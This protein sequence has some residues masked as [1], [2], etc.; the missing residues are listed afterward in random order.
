MPLNTNLQDELYDRL[1][2]YC[3]NHG[4]PLQP[5]KAY[6]AGEYIYRVNSIPMGFYRLTQ[7]GI[8]LE[9]EGEPFS[10]PVIRII[11]PHEFF[12]GIGPILQTTCLE[13]AIVFDEAEVQLFP[14]NIFTSL[15]REDIGFANFVIKLCCERINLSE[16]RIASLVTLSGKQRLALF[17]L[18]LEYVH[19][20]P[21]VKASL[22]IYLLK[23]DIASLIGITPE[24]VSRYL[25][26]FEK[27]HYIKLHDKSIEI[28][29]RKALLTMGKSRRA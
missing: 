26:D 6:E 14:K 17:L 16:Q 3:K 28:V 11:N 22:H 8:K 12:G 7:G 25:A 1:S 9:R 5:V 2:R 29:N 15:A 10:S 4:I 20:T 23:K 19:D 13:D 27:K 21:P 24:T 18:G